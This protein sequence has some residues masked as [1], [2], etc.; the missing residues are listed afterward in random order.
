MPNFPPKPYSGYDY[1]VVAEIIRDADAAVAK[2]YKKG[3]GSGIVTLQSVLQSYEHVLPRHGVKPDEDTYYYRLLLKLSLDPEP[4]WWAK[5]NRETGTKDGRAAFFPASA[6]GVSSSR[7]TPRTSESRPS[8]IYRASPTRLP[9]AS[10]GTGTSV[11]PSGSSVGAA[12]PSIRSGIPT[13]GGGRVS[14]RALSYRSST[15]LARSSDIELQDAIREATAQAVRLGAS[16]GASQDAAG[17]SVLLETASPPTEP[18][19]RRVTPRDIPPEAVRGAAAWA[20]RE[21]EARVAA[22]QEAAASA[23]EAAHQAAREAADR[24]EQAAFLAAL[25]E[26]AADGEARENPARFAAARQA[27]ARQAAA[28]LEVEAGHGEAE[29][30]EAVFA[31]HEAAREAAEQAAAAALAAEAAVDAARD[32]AR[33]SYDLSS[34]RFAVRT[35]SA[36]LT[37]GSLRSFAPTTHANSASVATGSNDGRSMAPQSCL[38]SDGGAPSAPLFSDDGG[39]ISEYGAPSSR[40]PSAA[41]L[42]TRNASGF[43][44]HGSYYE[45]NDPGSSCF[46]GPS[47]RSSRVPSNAAIRVGQSASL[48]S[49][50]TGGS[51]GAAG[52]ARS[53]GVDRFMADAGA[54]GRLSA[55]GGG[56][57]TFDSISMVSGRTGASARTGVSG[58]TGASGISSAVPQSES[59]VSTGFLTASRSGFYTGSRISSVAPSAGTRRDSG[60]SAGARTGGGVNGSMMRSDGGVSIDTRA[61]GYI[62]SVDPIS[63]VRSEAGISEAA[64]ASRRSSSVMRASGRI[65]PVELQGGSRSGSPTSLGMRTSGRISAVQRI[66]GTTSVSGTSIGTHAS[67]RQGSAG[68]FGAAP[69]ENGVSARSHATGRSGGARPFV[70]ARSEAGVSVVS[71]ATG[72][73]GNASVSGHDGRG[74]G[75]SVRSDGRV[76]TGSRGTGRISAA[77]QMDGAAS[78]SVYM[79]SSANDYRASRSTAGSGFPPSGAGGSERSAGPS[80]GTVRGPGSSARGIPASVSAGGG[81]TYSSGALGGVAYA[82][83]AAGRNSSSSAG[84]RGG[85]SSG[86]STLAYSSRVASSSFAGFRSDAGDSDFP[87]RETGNPDAGPGAATI[88]SGSEA[89]FREAAAAARESGSFSAPASPGAISPSGSLRKGSSISPVPRRMG[90]VGSGAAQVQGYGAWSDG[91]GVSG[92][93]LGG[94][95]GPGSAVTARG[96]AGAL[97]NASSRG[98]GGSDTGYRDPGDDDGFSFHSGII[99]GSIRSVVSSDGRPSGSAAGM[100]PGLHPRSSSEGFM[101]AGVASAGGFG[102][103]SG[104]GAESGGGGAGGI[105]GLN[106]GHPGDGQLGGRP[107]YDDAY[108]GGLQVAAEAT[109]GLPHAGGSFAGAAFCQHPPETAIPGPRPGPWP[110]S[111]APPWASGGGSSG[112]GAGYLNAGMYSSSGDGGGWGSADS[113]GA[114]APPAHSGDPP[115]SPEA[116]ESGLSEEAEAYMDFSRMARAFRTW[117]RNTSTRMM[118]RS[119]RDQALHNWAVATSFWAVQLLQR[120]FSRWRGLAPRKALM[121]ASIWGDNSR[122]GCFRRWLVFTRYLRSKSAQGVRI[123]RGR[124]LQRSWRQWRLYTWSRQRKANA[125]KRALD[126]R[127]DWMLCG[128]WRLWQAFTVSKR[129]KAAAA[130]KAVCFWT[131]RWLRICWL[132]W[133]QYTANKRRMALAM[134]R[135]ELFWV[136]R[137]LFSSWLGWRQYTLAKR[138]KML[139]VALAV[140]YWMGTSLRGCWRQWREYTAKRQYKAVAVGKALDLWTGRVLSICWATWTK[141]TAKQQRKALGVAKAEDFWRE[142]T[143]RGCFLEW[144]LQVEDSRRNWQLS[145]QMHMPPTCRHLPQALVD[146]HSARNEASILLRSALMKLQNRRLRCAFNKLRAARVR[147]QWKREREAMA[148]EWRAG[149]CLARSW[150]AWRAAQAQSVLAVEAA[151]D[152]ALKV[153]R[154]LLRDVFYGWLDWHE[155]KMLRRS[156]DTEARRTMDT[157]RQRLVLRAWRGTV[158]EKRHLA[159][160]AQLIMRNEVQRIMG[161]A[162]RHLRR[163][164]D[165]TRR[166]A[167]AR[168]VVQCG[169]A[170]RCLR[171]WKALGRARQVHHE[172]RAQR[173]RLAAVQRTRRLLTAWQL[174]A[175][176]HAEHQRLVHSCL[177]RSH[178][179]RAAAIIGAW[180][181]RVLD[182]VTKRMKMLA[183]LLAWERGVKARAWRAWSS[184]RDACRAS[185]SRFALAARRHRTRRLGLC[186]GAL[187]ALWQQHRELVARAVRFRFVHAAALLSDVLA[188]WRQLIG[189]LHLKNM[190]I[191]RAVMHARHRLL[192]GSLYGWFYV[193]RDRVATKQAVAVAVLHWVRRRRAAAL[194]WWRVWAVTERALRLRCEGFALVRAA[195]S[196]AWVLLMLRANVIRNAR[197]AGAVAHRKRYMARLAL[198]GWL[199][200]TLL[201]GEWVNRLRVVAVQLARQLLAYSL[202]AWMEFIEHRRRKAGMVGKALHYWRLGRQRSAL[203]SLRWHATRRQIMRAAV[204]RGRQ[205]AAARVLRAWRQEADYRRGLRDRYALMIARSRR[206]ALKLGVD[207]WRAFLALRAFR[208]DQQHL[209]QLHHLRATAARALLSWYTYHMQ[210]R[211]AKERAQ[212]IVRRWR[213]RDASEVLAAF[214]ENVVFQRQMRDAVAAF[215][216]TC[217]RRVF[218][219]WREFLVVKRA[220][221]FW[222]HNRLAEVLATWRQ[223]ALWRRARRAIGERIALRWR[224]LTAAMALGAWRD[225]TAARRRLMQIGFVLAN[226][227]TRCAIG[228]MLFAWLNLAARSAHLKRTG[229]ELAARVRASTLSACLANWRAATARRIHLRRTGA[230]LTARLRRSS[231]AAAFGFW[232]WHAAN[233]ARLRLVSEQIS[234]RQR[235]GLMAATLA[236]WCFQVARA[237]RLRSAQELVQ[238]RLRRG[239]LGAVL[240]AWRGRVAY[241]AKLRSSEGLLTARMR[242]GTAGD[243]LAEWHTYAARRAALRAAERHMSTRLHLSVL[244][245]LFA[246]WLG[247]ARYKAR[248]KAACQLLTLRRNHGVLLTVFG[249]WSRRAA[250]KARLAAAEAH[251]LHRQRQGLL[252]ETCGAWRELAAYKARLRR[253]GARVGG[254]W[255][256]RVLA[257]VWCDW[258]AYARRMAALKALLERVLVRATALAFYGWREMV[259][260]AQRWRAVQEGLA[261]R[262]EQKPALGETAC[263]AVARL[264]MWPLSVAFYTWYDN[265]RETRYLRDRTTDAVFAYAGGLM[266]KAWAIWL[267]YALRRR[268]VRAKLIR[269]RAAARIKTKDAVM[270][271]WRHMVW[272]NGRLR[273]AASVLRSKV[274]RQAL[275]SALELWRDTAARWAG[276]KGILARTMARTMSA[277]WEAWMEQV[278]EGRQRL[279]A[280]RSIAARGSRR[281]LAVALRAW[282]RLVAAINAARCLLA[283]AQRRQ[284]EWAWAVWQEAV[285]QAGVER[286]GQLHERQVARR[287]LRGWQG[288]AADTRR[289]AQLKAAMQQRLAHKALMEWRR[290]WVVRASCRRLYCRRALLGWHERTQELRATRARLWHASRV[291]LFGCLARCFSAW[292]QLTQAMSIK[293]A[294][295]VRKQRALAEALRRGDE[296]AA[297]R[298]AELA[299]LTFRAWGLRAS[300]GKEVRRRQAALRA[301]TATA[302][303]GAWR[304]YAR[305]RRVRAAKQDAVTRRRLLAR[306]LAVWR[307]AAA[308]LSAKMER[309]VAH[310]RLVLLDAALTAWQLH[311]GVMEQRRRALRRALAAG[312][313]AGAAALRARAW[314]AWC[315]FMVRRM[316]LWEL[317]EQAFQRRCRRV[318]GEAFDV[319]LK[320]TQAMRSGGI[321]PGSPYLTPRDRGADRWLVT[322]MAALAGNEQALAVPESASLPAGLL[323]GLYPSSALKAALERRQEVA[324]FLS[325]A[326]NPASAGGARAGGGVRA[327]GGTPATAAAT[328]ALTSA[329]LVERQRQRERRDSHGSGSAGASGT[330]SLGGSSHGSTLTST[331]SSGAGGA[332]LADLAMQVVRATPAL[333]LGGKSRGPM[334]AAPRAGAGDLVGIGGSPYDDRLDLRALYDIIGPHAGNPPPPPVPFGGFSPARPPG[335]SPMPLPRAAAT[336]A[337]PSSALAHIAPRRI[338]FTGGR[339]TAGVAGGRPPV[340][341]DRDQHYY[342][343]GTPSRSQ[344]HA[345][346]QQYHLGPPYSARADADSDVSSTTSSDLLAP[347]EARARAAAAAAAAAEDAT[348]AAS[349]AAMVSSSWRR[350]ATPAAGRSSPVKG[351]GGGGGWAASQGTGGKGRGGGG[352]AYSSGGG[353]GGGGSRMPAAGSGRLGAAGGGMTGGNGAHTSGRQG[354]HGGRPAGGG[355]GGGGGGGPSAAAAAAAGTAGG[356]RGSIL[357]RRAVH[358]R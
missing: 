23:R 215:R 155:D 264:R 156:R 113:S 283:H 157:R 196:K 141:F 163:E 259:H 65:S 120:C 53:F 292:W 81:S 168:R 34:G 119:E 304:E 174:V 145:Q 272:Y 291:I 105:H 133:R 260:E 306:P 30:G 110:G 109:Y 195:R 67:G 275:R 3:A 56:S 165:S 180:H 170:R 95:T 232:V 252:A 39:E 214:A 94:G 190:R 182:S 152:F 230:E 173:V 244:G 108:G 224:S 302:V 218:M 240:T 61:S 213:R 297:R 74:F 21:A 80:A 22:A 76:S 295:F 13:I 314:E 351:G 194:A 139:L 234:T 335:D 340:A 84:T 149:R 226:R 17:R 201:A 6:S 130:K 172:W 132:E 289:G 26:A 82:A 332:D 183:A 204:A 305:V 287:V 324:A 131:D 318:L 162:I 309:A 57:G 33:G 73:G 293:R 285:F 142:H 24:E 238:A 338:D 356:F 36:T 193:A 210:L 79:G 89:S 166:A 344:Q 20:A 312:A 209:A 330:V 62:S 14:A 77:D 243:V 241:T 311:H 294:V 225:F 153:L 48:R 336:P 298:N 4:D 161:T 220:T 129:R 136:Q 216:A 317:V 75:G 228:A 32:A 320:Y 251:V 262:M 88:F 122:A 123:W 296:L 271:E 1:G 90:S 7:P 277:A 179:R 85:Q 29:R 255:R 299:E 164:H 333:G 41:S 268:V 253:A 98:G 154:P 151:R 358:G 250:Y 199:L 261:T 86:R 78:D 144:V 313:A 348:A 5:L 72:R 181:E 150:A 58:R 176:L 177:V 221:D 158:L 59:G 307:Q 135:S 288:L 51:S 184:H 327:G 186:F 55:D 279:Q 93:Q 38:L 54:A 28:R 346:V 339:G 124:L 178:R 246:V 284:L 329:M 349:A 42:G 310:R 282:R 92:S 102:H 134:R 50:M 345:P 341:H 2:A 231:L 303:L 160:A 270:R 46:Q 326:R 263:Y 112:G 353:S 83:G 107:E 235:R 350:G 212:A 127:A 66:P 321:D 247:R 49:M 43:T 227:T 52:S 207:R 44:E 19:T 115:S 187:L 106:Y 257:E 96:S 322:R 140:K 147:G 70:G 242:A 236:A 118:S 300:M 315:E 219:A 222:T 37:E 25:A 355:T 60:F 354:P 334:A 148:L 40:Y 18:A 100:G 342:G 101:R 9:R 45:G 143:F 27:A 189:L 146:A 266:R 114:G 269:W 347:A 325:M 323:D 278:V 233:S 191:R 8:S 121:A 71:H 11:R 254:R 197:I 319:W 12:T 188:A 111:G 63:G 328:A 265:V 167:D 308:A 126:H 217:T 192:A 245:G 343:Y 159:S 31:A 64:H 35:P 223:Y 211:R 87:R 237:A 229:A 206:T 116:E 103:V 68:S 352:A 138:R 239:S 248:L 208:R 256:R 104:G 316:G 267:A 281:E 16:W 274:G 200:R 331:L 125:V 175:C 286:G 15:S 117:R 273:L 47:Q 205:G 357:D 258:A 97:Q 203:D 301:R 249:G 169:A 69:S 171:H 185:A 128:C 280:A 202:A 337:N 91:G 137:E 10:A 198:S 99:P 290:Q 276:L